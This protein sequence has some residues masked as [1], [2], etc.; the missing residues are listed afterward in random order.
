MGP[1]TLGNAW[2]HALGLLPVRVEDFN[3]LISSCAKALLVQ[4]AE[5]LLKRMKET[6]LEASLVTYNTF[7]AMYEKSLSFGKALGAF[8][9]LQMRSLQPDVFTYSSMISA[10]GRAQLK[11]TLELFKSMEKS[12]VQKNLICSSAS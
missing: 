7:I 5:M 12:E 11:N 6:S 1:A 10:S 4:R 2:A 3:A 8:Q 9:E